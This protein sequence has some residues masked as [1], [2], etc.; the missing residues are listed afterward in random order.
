MPEYASFAELLK[1]PVAD[2]ALIIQARFPMP[3]YVVTEEGG[4]QARFLISKVNPSQTHTNPS[5]FAYGGQVRTNV[6][7]A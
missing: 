4:S 7:L 5:N 1:A 6:R 2:A 3:R